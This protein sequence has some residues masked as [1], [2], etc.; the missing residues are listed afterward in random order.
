MKT[1]T[2]IALSILALAAVTLVGCSTVRG[3]GED[4]SAAGRG[5]SDAASATGKAIT[6]EK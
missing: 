6:G 5:I 4:I 2:L 3:A 1:R